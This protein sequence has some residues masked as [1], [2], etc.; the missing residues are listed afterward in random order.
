M[1]DLTTHY[2]GIPLQTPLLVAAC[3]VSA[4]LDAVKRAEEAGAGGLVIRS[5][6]EEQLL[7]D[8]QR[9]DDDLAVGSE[10]FAEALSYFPGLR[11]G[12]AR[13]HLLAIEKMRK[14]VRM[15]LIGSL[16]ATSA[17]SW[18]AY[19]RQLAS[20][21]VDA[22]ELNIYA[23]AAD[24]ERTGAEIEAGVYEIFEQVRDEVALP[25]SVKLS[26]YYSSVANV[27]RNLDARRVRGLVLFNRFLQPDIDP[28]LELV[29]G[30]M[31]LSSPE[32]I[33]LPLRWAGLLHGRIHADIALSTGV[34]TGADIAKAILA[35]AN[36]VQTAAA[37][38]RNG[39]PY[40]STMLRAFEMW[41]TDREYARVEDFRGHLS[42]KN[43][44]DPFAFERAQYVGLLLSKARTGPSL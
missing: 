19:A 33:R 8:R 25:V 15:P 29:R 34:H 9:L 30:D 31:P 40:L 12:D 42:Q 4:R 32:E 27:A 6:F 37:L 10:S 22:I 14:A 41:M 39:V 21:G 20:A 1:I 3:P 7:L 17:G 23:V 44:A 43:V 16:N 35:G 24:P 18:T 5:L 36:V 28:E 2:L 11:H 38:M 13:E 26:P